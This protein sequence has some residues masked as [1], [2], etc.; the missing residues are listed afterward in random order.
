[1]GSVDL[2]GIASGRLGPSRRV[3]EFGHD[4]CQVVRLGHL[5][6]CGPALPCGGEQHE[7]RH[8][9]VDQCIECEPRHRHRRHQQ[10]PALGG[11]D[12]RDLAVMTQ[13]D[14]HPT[15]GGVHRI[16]ERS[17]TG[18]EPIVGQPWLVT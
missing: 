8:R 16:G 2:D 6:R 11:V 10:R 3:G 7:F 1:M 9:V 5:V 12:L 4:P 14:A 18:D 15:T 17:Q 13:L